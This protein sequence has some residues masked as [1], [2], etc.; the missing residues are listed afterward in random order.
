M[1]EFGQPTPIQEINYRRNPENGIG[2]TYLD[3]LRGEHL[4]KQD[5]RS[6]IETVDGLNSAII[7]NRN[8]DIPSDRNINGVLFQA[9]DE[10]VWTATYLF[11]SLGAWASTY[12]SDD[13]EIVRELHNAYITGY[14]DGRFYPHADE[15]LI[16][17]DNPF[18]DDDEDPE[19]EEVIEDEQETAVSSAE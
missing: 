13:K 6:V 19:Q 16:D 4:T 14:A 5:L 17:F 10:D 11:D 8:P 12:Q 7:L 2:G 15:E 9:G 18:A 1:E 3:L